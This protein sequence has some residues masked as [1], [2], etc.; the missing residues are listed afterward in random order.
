[1]DEV[2]RTIRE[3]PD[4]EVSS[5]GRVAH[6]EQDVLM[7]VSHTLQ[8]GL[9][10][11]LTE[12]GKQYTRSIRRLVAD[13]FVDGKDQHFNTPIILD[14][15]QNN[16][17]AQN[18]AWRPRWFAWHY[19]NQFKDI[20]DIYRQGP[21][22]EVDPSGEILE[23]YLDTYEVGITFGLL[24]YEVWRCLNTPYD[25]P[26]VFPTGQIFDWPNKV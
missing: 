7:R 6:K 9:K 10:V 21:I 4:Y 13:A 11:G 14:G 5:Y 1:M 25:K 18:L 26:R 16:C 22:V 20:P 23:V 15:D 17:S 8:G 19:T 24:F 12:D 3:F 2:W